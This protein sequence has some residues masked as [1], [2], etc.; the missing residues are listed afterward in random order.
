MLLH[1]QRVERL[2]QLS[3]FIQLRQ[4]HCER[5]CEHNAQIF[6]P[7]L[8]NHVI[9]NFPIFF[10]FFL[11]P[12][13]SNSSRIFSPKDMK[14]QPA[15]IFTSL[16]NAKF[17]SIVG[18]T[19]CRPIMVCCSPFWKQKCGLEKLRANLFQDAIHSDLVR[20]RLET[21]MESFGTL[22]CRW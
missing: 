6:A 12:F 17:T 7:F 13:L 5:H 11:F 4:K 1:S 9:S 2:N 16:Q 8:S 20:L 22:Y 3:A 21:F 15:V 18:Y 14:L 19:C 10:F